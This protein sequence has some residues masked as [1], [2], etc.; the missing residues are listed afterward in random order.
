VLRAPPFAELAPQ[1]G[2]QVAREA[3]AAAGRGLLFIVVPASVPLS[4][5]QTIRQEHRTGG[6]TVLGVFAAFLGALPARFQ[7][8]GSRT[9]PGLP[10]V[11]VYVYRG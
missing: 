9:F 1:P 7:P 3:A 11:T 6:A 10:P 2:A 5:L 8:V 4:R